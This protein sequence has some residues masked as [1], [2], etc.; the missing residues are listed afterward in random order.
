MEKVKDDYCKE[1]FITLI[2]IDKK[3]RFNELHR[4]LN[5]KGAKISKPTLI[6]HLNHLVEKGIIHRKENKKQNVSYEINWK[7]FKQLQKA[8]YTNEELM[9]HI[10]NEEI[11]KSKSLDQ[12]I[13]YTTAM[14]TMENLMHLKFSI[15]NIIEPQDKLQNYYSHAL[16]HKLFKPYPKWLLDT[17]KPSKEN[18]EKA[19][20]SLDKSIKSLQ[21]TFFENSL[22]SITDVPSKNEPQPRSS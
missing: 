16:L 9:H 3:V 12:Q 4:K 5:V 2:I 20:K 6:Q 18:S 1:I 8:M 14:L 13:I 11:F 19:L 21:E 17:C 22:E 10:K 7:K 15:L